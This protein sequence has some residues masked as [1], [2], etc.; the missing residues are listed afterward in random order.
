MRRPE[1]A[2]LLPWFASALAHL[3]PGSQHRRK[4][5]LRPAQ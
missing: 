2:D 3:G 5:G 1:K 4:Y